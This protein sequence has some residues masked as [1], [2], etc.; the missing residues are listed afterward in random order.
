MKIVCMKIAMPNLLSMDPR[1]PSPKTPSTHP[2]WISTFSYR[3]AHNDHHPLWLLFSMQTHRNRM[4]V[5]W[6]QSYP[7]PV[8]TGLADISPSVVRCRFS[9]SNCWP[10]CCGCPRR[11]P[12]MDRPLTAPP[13]PTWWWGNCIH[14]HHNPMEF[15]CPSV[16]YRRDSVSHW[17]RID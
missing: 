7:S 4:L 14:C 3:W 12:P 1:W 17:H 15:Q 2:N 10:A 8:S 13:P 16:R 11:R 9:S 6:A 5:R